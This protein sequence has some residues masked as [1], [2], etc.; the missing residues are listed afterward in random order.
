MPI[1]VLPLFIIGHFFALFFG[2][3]QACHDKKIT[4]QLTLWTSFAAVWK[5]YIV[6][7]NCFQHD[8][9]SYRNA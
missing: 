1:T 7:K 6:M 2:V 9:K 4:N 8:N 3:Y 5:N